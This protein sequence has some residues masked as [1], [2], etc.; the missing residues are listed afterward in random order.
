MN[1][2]PE[3]TETKESSENIP[4]NKDNTTNNNTANNN[5]TNKNTT[6]N[7][8]TNNNPTNNNNNIMKIEEN[9]KVE[10]ILFEGIETRDDDSS[11]E[12]EYKDDFEDDTETEI[13]KMGRLTL[14]KTKEKLNEILDLYKSQLIESQK[15]A[16]TT[17]Y[18]GN[19][20]V[21]EED[22]FEM[23]SQ[24]MSKKKEDMIN[25]VIMEE[26]KQEEKKE[27]N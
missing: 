7:N 23:S 4:T 13:E 20:K 18:E 25:K 12:E 27:E 10:D 9:E 17:L 21:I 22:M 14:P 2:I 24:E 16:Q 19:L 15:L 26:N 11:L 5:L 6:N 8:P 1:E 3:R